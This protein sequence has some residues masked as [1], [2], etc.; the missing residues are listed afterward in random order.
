M[1]KAPGGTPRPSRVRQGALFFSILILAGMAWLAIK[2]ASHIKGGVPVRATATGARKRAGAAPGAG[3][4][5][6]NVPPARLRL[7][8]KALDPEVMAHTLPD[9]AA[10]DPAFKNPCWH[11]G[12]PTGPLQC[13]PYLYL[14]GGFQSGAGTLY[15]KL[16]EHPDIVTVRRAA[17]FLVR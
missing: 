8:G 12:G 7:I 4:N 17:F 11:A 14:L 3:A 1:S 2:L 9:D 5:L 10:F 6:L 15:A 13:L 16:V